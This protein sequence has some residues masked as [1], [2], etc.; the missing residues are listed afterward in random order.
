[1][2]PDSTRYI[3][4][5]LAGILGLALGLGLCRPALAAPQAPQPP[6]VIYKIDPEHK[7]P[8]YYDEVTALVSMQGI[9]NRTRPTLYV[10]NPGYGRPRYWLDKLVAPG[11]W[12]QGR[13]QTEITTLDQVFQ[14]AR[15]KLKGA[16]IWDPEVPATINV[17]TTAAGVED[18][19]VL[20]PEMAD[21][22]LKPW[23]LKVL[24]DFRGMFTGAQTGS[25][26]NDAYRWAIRQYLDTGKC[27]SHFICLYHDAA[28]T[29]ADGD[30]AY[31]I[32]RDWPITNRAFTF[33]LSPWG[34]ELPAD[35][36]GQKLGTDLETYKMVLAAT[37]RRSAGRGMT[38]MAG[39]F[40][41]W[42]Y[43]NVQGHPSKHD[44]VPT[45]W[46]TVWLITPYNCYQ[47]TA[48]EF[49]YNQ[50][51]HRHAP[52]ASLK[53]QWRPADVKLKP[54]SYVAFLMAD[55]DSAYP[56]YHFLP[57]NWDDPHRGKLPLNWGFN[58]NLLETYPDI[59]STFYET[60]TPN[61]HFI[62]DASAA[63]YMNPNRVQERYLPLF[64]RHNRKFYRMADMTI[65]GMV[66][67]WQ[68]PTAAVKDAFR[69][70]SPD[71]YATILCDFHGGGG[72]H[73]SPE[74]WRGMP[75]TD[76]LG[77]DPNSVEWSADVM[78]GDIKKREPGKPGFY[79]YRCVWVTPT[80]I[81]AVLDTFRKKNPAEEIEVIDL[82]TFFK[83]F[84]QYYGGAGR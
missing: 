48:T 53:Q 82:Q 43:A 3:N 8:T 67:D 18:A 41:F 37:Q 19:V 16:V 45:E 83:L 76:L 62:A 59:I 14:L 78:A 1:M 34:D 29:R 39:F 50:S 24:R 20:S 63:G 75:V 36:P 61:D 54:K 5:R 58:P 38:E 2:G 9:V 60:R 73:K 33:D 27:S 30:V 84:K 44:P 25:K 66:L 70:F 42:K 4:G 74:V 10:D 6:M 81:Q 51:F 7:G 15:P 21:R 31:N 64:A 49:C 17:A 12:L 71:G 55:Y 57:T 28:R 56:L 65:S 26:K 32:I 13:E 46:E 52:L 47:N 11:H 69:L 40:S 79:Y 68:D 35:D 80:Q 23:R 22:Y 77:M 72:K